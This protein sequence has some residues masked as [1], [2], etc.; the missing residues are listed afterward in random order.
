MNLYDKPHGRRIT[1]WEAIKRT[2]RGD[3]VALSPFE[4]FPRDTY[5]FLRWV[6]KIRRHPD[7]YDTIDF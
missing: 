1:L 4:K 3:E 6:W 7:H 5:L 2:W